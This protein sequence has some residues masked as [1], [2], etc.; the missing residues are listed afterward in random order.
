MSG[1]ELLKNSFA[2]FHIFVFCLILMG[3][4]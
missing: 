4:I 2:Y 3:C 1:V